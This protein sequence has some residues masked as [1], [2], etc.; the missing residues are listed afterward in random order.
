[1]YRISK[2]IDGDVSGIL[3]LSDNA[4]IPLAPANTDY[5]AFKT[6]INTG[7]AQLED[8]DGHLMT[9]EAAKAFVAA[10]QKS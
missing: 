1:M 8:A 6:Q 7:K 5:Q 2:N 3:R 4:L 9:A 10:L